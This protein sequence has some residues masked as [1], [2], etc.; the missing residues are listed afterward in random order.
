MTM[1]ALVA[2]D[3]RVTV[4]LLRHTLQQ[5]DLDVAVAYDG[6]EAW[7]ILQR[8][9]TIG[10]VILDWSMPGLDGLEICRRIRA[11]AAREHLHVLLLTAHDGAAAIVSGL[12]AGADDYLSKPFDPEVFRARVHVGLRILRLK[13]RL[14]ERVAEL[15]TALARVKQLHGLLPICRYCKQVRSDTGYWEQVE[16]YV[17]HHTDLQFSHGVCPECYERVVAE[18]DPTGAG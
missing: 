6:G 7:D 9:P 11:D 14:A 12:D 13:E 10:L 17:S 5:W 3:D 18:L 16:T 1:R 15:E 8:D 4:E 2:D